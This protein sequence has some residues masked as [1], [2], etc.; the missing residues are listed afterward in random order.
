MSTPIK[1]AAPPPP[2]WWSPKA[3]IWMSLAFIAIAGFPYITSTTKLLAEG[4][5]VTLEAVKG[6]AKKDMMKKDKEHGMLDEKKQ[7]E[8]KA[9][10][11]A[12]DGTLYAG[13]HAGVLRWKD[14]AWEKLGGYE[15]AEAKLITTAPD[16]S[17]LVAGKH[18]AYRY[19]SG[20]WTQVYEDDVHSIS[21]T[22]DGTLYISGPKTGLKKK[23]TGGDWE[24]VSEGFPVPSAK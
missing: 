20:A 21:Q 6:E 10:T 17:L 4:K 16:G 14:G 1:P 24:V 8:I 23:A 3:A 15:D 5:P 18:G 22:A 7:R 12:A 13:G 9:M 19:A 2:T 11:V